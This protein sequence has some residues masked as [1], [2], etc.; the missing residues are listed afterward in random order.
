MKPLKLAII[1]D[2]HHGPPRYTKKGAEALPLLESFV[3]E[4]SAG[5]FDAVVD[6]GDRITNVDKKTDGELA[7]EVADIFR[8]INVPTYH[9]LGNHDLY[10]LTVRENEVLLGSNLSSRSID[11]KGKHLVFWNIDLSNTYADNQI[12]SDSDLSWLKTDL[13]HTELPT[14]IFTHI[15]LDNASMVGN[16]WFQNNVD[17]ASLKNTGRA[18]KIIEASGK[19]ILCIAGHT[20]WNKLSNIDGIHYLTIQSLSESFTTAGM[21]SEAWAELT[22]DEVL[23]C[24]VHGNDRMLS[25]VA[26]KKLHSHWISP[27][28]AVRKIKKGSIAGVNETIKGLL[29][30]MDGVIYTGEEAIPGSPKAIRLIQERGI[31]IIFLTNNARLSPDGYVRKL[32]QLGITIEPENII[33]S[34]VA[35]ENFV[36]ALDAP[37][38]VHIIG[39]TALR[40]LVLAAGALES[41]EAEYVIA[42]I[43]LGLDMG[44]LT[45]AVR[46]LINGAKLLATNTDAIIPAHDGPEPEAGSVVAFLEAAS[47]QRAHDFGKPQKAI[48]DLA[49]E[50]AGVSRDSIVMI[51]DTLVTD[52]AGARG[53]GLR[54]ILV[55]SGNP[56]F[57]LEQD[58]M[59]TMRAASLEQALPLILSN[60]E[61]AGLTC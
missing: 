25:E 28:P 9:L 40:E 22:I 44:D 21:A 10:Y 20:H 41:D 8:N 55:E 47:G 18:R 33:T 49:I 48:F 13:N 37:P 35:V 54:S 39:S 58:L 12:P 17:A 43:D 59:P 32:E 53:A 30:D 3:N 46:H 15:P 2:I 34:G 56:I 52:I 29:I 5:N 50:R 57:D 16:F 36:R 61:K 4:V 31:K 19:V 24:V 45:V 7:N 11:V 60:T 26:S 14:I 1:T 23:H 51:G 6:L 27:R 38:K 42:G